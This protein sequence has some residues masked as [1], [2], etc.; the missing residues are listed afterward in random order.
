MMKRRDT[1]TSREP[2]RISREERAM[3]RAVR[4]D[5]KQGAHARQDIVQNT[6][7]GDAKNPEGFVKTWRTSSRAWRWRAV[8]CAFLSLL[9]LM[10]QPTGNALY[11]SWNAATGEAQGLGVAFATGEGE[12]AGDLV[13]AEISDLRT[14]G[15]SDLGG[16]SLQTASTREWPTAS[17]AKIK[18]YASSD[19][20]DALY[21]AGMRQLASGSLP[22]LYWNLHDTDNEYAHGDTWNELAEPSAANGQFGYVTWLRGDDWDQVDDWEPDAVPGVYAWSLGYLLFGWQVV[23]PGSIVE[24][25]SNGYISNDEGGSSSGV[26]FTGY[27]PENKKTILPQVT[28]SEQYDSRGVTTNHL[29]FS[30]SGMGADSSAVG[31]GTYY[32]VPAY[33]SWAK[34]TDYKVSMKVVKAGGGYNNITN[35]ST[36]MWKNGIAWDGGGFNDLLKNASGS[37][38][39]Y[40]LLKNATG[41]TW[42]AWP[43]NT[44]GSK[45][46]TSSVVDGIV[47]T[48][49]STLG[50]VVNPGG[51]STSP[52][53]DP[54]SKSSG[55]ISQGG[56]AGRILLTPTFAISYHPNNDTGSDTVE[57]HEVNIDGDVVVAE[58]T[59]S[60][61]ILRRAET[62]VGGTDDAFKGWSVGAADDT[63]EL[64]PSDCGKT[65]Q[66]LYDEGKLT[67]Y[68]TKT[69]YE[70]VDYYDLVAP[71]DLYAVWD[72]PAVT[73]T[74]NYVLNTDDGSIELSKTT[75]TLTGGLA[76]SLL[77]APTLQNATD[78]SAYSGAKYSGDFTWS[79][80]DTTDSGASFD[81]DTDTPTDSAHTYTVTLTPNLETYTVT[82][83]VDTDTGAFDNGVTQVVVNKVP[84]GTTYDQIKFDLINGAT[85][86]SDGKT[87]TVDY[88]SAKADTLSGVASAGAGIRGAYSD[89]RGN[90]NTWTGTWS[91]GGSGID[92]STVSV[93]GDTTLTYTYGEGYNKVTFA[94]GSATNATSTSDTTVTNAQATSDLE[95]S[96]SEA[97]VA[98]SDWTPNGIAAA[99]KP[100]AALKSSVSDY[101]LS[102]KYAVTSSTATLTWSAD[103][104]GTG[105]AHYDTATTFTYTA[106]PTLR[107]FTV[108]F[109]VRQSNGNTNANILVASGGADTVNYTTVPYGAYANDST[110]ITSA[111]VS[112]VYIGTSA[113]QTYSTENA[114][115]RRQTASSPN[116]T[117]ETIA[118]PSAVQVTKN[119]VIQ[120]LMGDAHTVT[121][122]VEGGTINGSGSTTNGT[123]ATFYVAGVPDGKAVDSI[124]YLTSSGAG[125]EASPY[126]YST[127]SGAVNVDGAKVVNTGRNT[128]GTWSSSLFADRAALS[129]AGVT[130]TA[131]AALSYEFGRDTVTV[132]YTIAD[133][134]QWTSG[135]SATIIGTVPYGKTIA[136]GIS[137]GTLSAI[138]DPTASGVV[139]VTK[140]AQYY[141]P[142]STGNAGTWSPEPTTNT[143]VE[144]AAKTGGS[145]VQTYAYTLKTRDNYSITYTIPEPYNTYVK[146]S[147]GELD[148]K[149]SYTYTNMTYGVAAGNGTGEQAAPPTAL[150][151]DTNSD[152]LAKIFTGGT[153][154]ITGWTA[155]DGTATY[156]QGITGDSTYYAQLNLIDYTVTYA[157]ENGSW[158]GSPA[159]SATYT[160]GQKPTGDIAALMSATGADSARTYNGTSVVTPSATYA[161]DGGDWEGVWTMTVDG[162]TT[163]LADGVS[164]SD[165]AITGNTIFTLT[166][167]RAVKVT[168]RN[169]STSIASGG[170]TDTT[171]WYFAGD[172]L[173]A[174]AFTTATA[175]TGYTKTSGNNRTSPYWTG[176]GE[177]PTTVPDSATAKTYTY[178]LRAVHTVTYKVENG[179]WLTWGSDTS[180][181]GTTT[182][183]SEEL[184][185]DV[186]SYTVP[187][188]ERTNNDY[189][190]TGSWDAEPSGTFTGSSNETH[191]YT[192]G[193][194]PTHAFTVNFYRQNTDLSTYETTPYSTYTVQVK[195]G[196]KQ[197]ITKAIAEQYAPDK[198]AGDPAGAFAL[199]TSDDG[200]AHEYT[201]GTSDITVAVYYNRNSFAYSYAY[202]YDSGTDDTKFR[203]P[204]VT[205]LPTGGTLPYGAELIIDTSVP[206]ASTPYY[207][208]GGWTTTAATISGGKLT[209]PASA[210]TLTGNWTRNS[211][212]LT[213]TNSDTGK[214]TISGT[215]SITAYQYGDSFTWP[216]VAVT[217]NTGVF[218]DKWEN[219]GTTGDTKKFAQTALPTTI[220]TDNMVFTT[221]SGLVATFS[222]TWNTGIKIQYVHDQTSV[223]GTLTNVG[224]FKEQGTGDNDYLSPDASGEVE[225][226]P[227]NTAENGDP[228]AAAY[229]EPGYEFLYW[230]WGEGANDH[231]T[232]SA[233][234]I[235]NPK[236]A[237]EKTD[238]AITFTAV[239]QGTPHN[240]TYDL[241][242]G[243]QTTDNPNKMTGGATAEYRTGAQVWLPSTSELTRAGCTLRGYSIKIG[244]ADAV[245]RAAT[246]SG[247]L[248]TI[249]AGTSDL[250]YRDII[251]IT[252]VYDTTVTF[253]IAGSEGVESA[254]TNAIDDANNSTTENL[255]ATVNLPTVTQSDTTMPTIANSTEFI[256]TGYHF[257][258]WTTSLP[259]AVLSIAQGDT[260]FTVPSETATDSSQGGAL[261]DFTGGITV[262]ANYAIDT[263]KTVWT[264]S[265]AELYNDASLDT[266]GYSLD[267]GKA[268]STISYGTDGD[269]VW[270][271]VAPTLT[272]N[273]ED[274]AKKY[275][276]TYQGIDWYL[277]V[278]GTP[279]EVKLQ[280]VDF[281]TPFYYNANGVCEQGDSGATPFTWTHDDTVTFV[282]VPIINQYTIKLAVEN[283]TM[284]DPTGDTLETGQTEVSYTVDYNTAY[285][286]FLE[287]DVATYA[288]T[289]DDAGGYAQ[290]TDPAIAWSTGSGTMTY[291]NIRE[292]LVTGDANVTTYTYTFPK[293]TY[294]VL[295]KIADAWTDNKAD[296][297]LSR[298]N[299]GTARPEI[300]AA[301]DSSAFPTL[302]AAS[303]WNASTLGEFTNKY[304]SALTWVL[305]NDTADP[306]TQITTGN[307]GDTM[308]DDA[309]TVTNT[310]LET[311]PATITFV[312]TPQTVKYVIKSNVSGGTFNN[313]TGVTDNVRTEDDDAVY[314]EMLSAYL[315]DV[316][317][318][319][320][321]FT[322]DDA[323][324]S[325]GHWETSTG[326][327]IDPATTPVTESETYVYVFDTKITV[328]MTVTNNTFATG[329]TAT[330][331]YYVAYNEKAPG[332]AVIANAV[333]SADDPTYVFAGSGTDYTEADAAAQLA[334][335]ANAASQVYLL[336]ALSDVQAT[337][338][339]YGY[340]WKTTG[341]WESSAASSTLTSLA[342]YPDGA[343]TGDPSS[344]SYP[345]VSAALTG[346][347]AYTYAME[348]KPVTIRFV[349]MGQNAED[350]NYTQIGTTSWAGSYSTSDTRFDS[351]V[352]YILDAPTAL[353]NYYGYVRTPVATTTGL[354]TETSGSY[355]VGTSAGDT[356]QPTNFSGTDTYYLWYDRMNVNYTY[357]YTNSAPTLKAGTELPAGTQTIR[358]GRAISNSTP[359]K[360]AA[361]I[362]ATYALALTVWNVSYNGF[363]TSSLTA[364]PGSTTYTFAPT[365]YADTSTATLDTL[366]ATLSGTWTTATYTVTYENA[367]GG[368]P[369]DDKAQFELGGTRAASGASVTTGAITWGETLG[370]NV[371]DV[372]VTEPDGEHWTKDKSDKYSLVGWKLYID[373]TQD[374]SVGTDG[375]IAPEDLASQVVKG[376]NYVYKPVFKLNQITITLSGGA[377]QSIPA[378]KEVTTW[379]VDYGTEIALP[380]TSVWASYT[381]TL[382]DGSVWVGSDAEIYPYADKSDAVRAKRVSDQK[383]VASNPAAWVTADGESWNTT[384]DGDGEYII[385]ATASKTYLYQWEDIL[386]EVYFMGITGETNDLKPLAGTHTARTLKWDSSV[387]SAALSTDASGSTAAQI[388]DAATG[389]TNRIL[390]PQWSGHTFLGWQNGSSEKRGKGTLAYPGT[391]I[392]VGAAYE[393]SYVTGNSYRIYLWPLWQGESL[394]VTFYK[395][396]GEDTETTKTQSME[397]D[398]ATNLLSTSDLGFSREGWNF[399][400]WTTE[401]DGA[402]INYVDGASYTVAEDSTA[403]QRSLY[404]K[405]SA[406]TY[407][408]RFAHFDGTPLTNAEVLGTTGAG[409]DGVYEQP[410][411]Y[412]TAANLATIDVDNVISA[413]SEHNAKGDKFAGWSYGSYTFTN[414]QEVSDLTAED[415]GVITLRPIATE[416]VKLTY[417]ANAGNETITGYPSDVTSFVSVTAKD[418]EGVS[419]NYA[420]FT[421][422]TA[423]ER[424]GYE[425]Q[426]WKITGAVDA[427]TDPVKAITT[428]PTSGDVYLS[429]EYGAYMAYAQWKA[430]EHTGYKIERW[431]QKEVGS[432]EYVLL[433]TD[434]THTAA[435]GDWVEIGSGALA[436]YS[437]SLD[438]Y[439]Y[440]PGLSTTGV[441]VT[442]GGTAAIVLKYN[443]D[444]LS[445]TYSFT[446]GVDGVEL[447]GAAAG[448]VPF[449]QSH[450]SLTGDSPMS[451]LLDPLTAAL[452]TGYEIVTGYGSAWRFAGP[453]GSLAQ[454]DGTAIVAQSDVAYDGTTAYTVAG[455][456]KLALPIVKK[457]FTVTFALG[458][459]AA[460]DTGA[461]ATGTGTITKTGV[462]YGSSVDP[463]DE[464]VKAVVTAVTN[465]DKE[466]GFGGWVYQNASDND[467]PK[468]GT[469]VDPAT[470]EIVGNTTFTAYYYESYTVTWSAGGHSA[471]GFSNTDENKRIRTQLPAAGYVWTAS[472][473]GATATNVGGLELAA[474]DMDAKGAPLAQDGYQFAGWKVSCSDDIYEVDSTTAKVNGT[475][476]ASLDELY[477]AVPPSSDYTIE[478]QWSKLTQTVIFD[479]NITG[480][481]SSSSA[482]TVSR[483]GL[484]G[485]TGTT[486]AAPDARAG[487]EFDCWQLS[488]DAT[489]QLGANK[490]FTFPMN[491]LDKA[492]TTYVAQWSEA[493]ININFAVSGGSGT[494]SQNR[495]TTQIKALDTSVEYTLKANP[496]P[497]Y[498]FVRWETSNTGTDISTWYNGSIT[499]KTHANY[500][501][502]TLKPVNGAYQAGTY[503]AVFEADPYEV[504]F[505][506]SATTGEGTVK[507]YY[508][509]D[510]KSFALV[511]YNQGVETV[512]DISSAT[513]ASQVQVSAEGSD[514]GY[515]FVGWSYQYWPETV[516]D[517]TGALVT[518][519]TPTSGTT[520]VPTDQLDTIPIV[521]KT[522][523][524]AVYEKNPS[525]ITYDK[526]ASAATGGISQ[527]TGLYTGDV[528][529]LPEA[530][531][532]ISWTGHTL[533]G[534]VTA[535]DEGNA[536]AVASMTEAEFDAYPYKAGA[537]GDEYAVKGGPETL[538]AMF[539]AVNA[540]L[541]YDNN[542]L[543]EVANLATHAT[544]N[545]TVKAGEDGTALSVDAVNWSEAYSNPPGYVSDDASETKVP[546][547]AREFVGWSFNANAALDG[548]SGRIFKAGDTIPASY[549]PTSATD[550][551]TI[552][553]IWKDKTFSVLL[554][555]N[556]GSLISGK[557]NPNPIATEVHY[558]D[559]VSVPTMMYERASHTFR[560]WI[561][562]DSSHTRVSDGGSYKFAGT[563]DVTLSAYWEKDADIVYKAQLTLKDENNNSL[564]EKKGPLTL[565]DTPLSDGSY[566]NLSVE[567]GS[568][569]DTSDYFTFLGWYM[570]TP[571]QANYKV[572]AGDGSV[573][574]N[575]MA[576]IDEIIKMFD[577]R[578]ASP[579]YW[580][581]TA[582]EYTEAYEAA[583]G[584]NYLQLTLYASKELK[585]YD[586]SFTENMPAVESGTGSAVTPIGDLNTFTANVS[587]ETATL[588]G[589]GYSLPGYRFLGWL[590]S[591]NSSTIDDASFASMSKPSDAVAKDHNLA[592][593][594]LS[595]SST[596]HAVTLYAAWGDTDNSVTFIEAADG[597]GVRAA[598]AGTEERQLAGDNVKQEDLTW[599]TQLAAVTNPSVHPE[600]EYADFTGWYTVNGKL[601][602]LETC[603]TVA[604]IVAIDSGLPMNDDGSYDIKLY[605]HYSFNSARVVYNGDGD[606]LVQ[607][608][609]PATKKVDIHDGAAPVATVEL[610]A[611]NQA[612]FKKAG[613]HMDGWEGKRNKGSYNN[614]ESGTNYYNQVWLDTGDRTVPFDENAA[615]TVVNVWPHY[616]E[617][618]YSVTYVYTLPDGYDSYVMTEAVPGK[619]SSN[620]N[621]TARTGLTWTGGSVFPR[622]LFKTAPV[623][624]GY[625][626]TGWTCTYDGTT[627]EVTS[628]WT[629][630]DMVNA[631]AAE[632]GV[633]VKDIEAAF[634]D[635]TFTLSAVWTPKTYAVAYDANGGL[636]ISTNAAPGTKTGV[637]WDA[638]VDGAGDGLLISASDMSKD[639]Y[640]AADPL[641]YVDSTLNTQ[642]GSTSN[643]TFAELVRAWHIA[644][645]HTAGSGATNK[646]P[647]GGTIKL[648]AKWVEDTVKISFTVS[649]AEN[650]WI[651]SVK[652]ADG[653]VLKSF[654]SL[655]S[656]QVDFVVGAKT[657]AVTYEGTRTTIDDLKVTVGSTTPG[658]SVTGWKSGTSTVAGA[659]DTY[660]VA[661][662]SDRYVNA[663]YE[664]QIE[665]D[666]NVEITVNFY[667]MDATGAYQANGSVTKHAG[668][669]L[670]ADNGTAKVGDVIPASRF[671]GVRTTVPE[672]LSLD[673]ST[674]ANYKVKA[675]G[676][677]VDLYY[678]RA[679]TDVTFSYEWP[680]GDAA[681]K[682]PAL[683]FDLQS[684]YYGSTQDVPDAPTAPAGYEFDGW[685]Q[686]RAGD[687]VATKLTPGAADGIA[688]DKL[689][690]V[691][692][693]G[694][695]TKKVYDVSFAG[696]YDEDGAMLSG[697]DVPTI[698]LSPEGF[699]KSVAYGATLGSDVCIVVTDTT[700]K[701]QPITLGTDSDTVNVA[702]KYDSSAYSITW[703]YSKDGT[704]WISTADPTKV[705]I[706]R[707]T[708]FR[709]IAS[710]AQVV[711]YMAGEHGTFATTTADGTRVESVAGPYSMASYLYDEASDDLKKVKAGPL[712]AATGLPTGEVGWRFAG[713]EWT[714]MLDAGYESKPEQTP[715]LAE[716]ASATDLMHAGVQDIDGL[717]YGITLTALWAPAESWLEV[718]LDDSTVPAGA[719]DAVPASFVDPSASPEGLHPTYDSSLGNALTLPG[720]DDVTR[721]GFTLTGWVATFHDD[722]TTAYYEA[723]AEFQMPASAKD[724]A[725]DPAVTLT[726]VWAEDY[727]T[728]NYY[729]VDNTKGTVDVA[730]ETVG[731]W[732]GKVRGSASATLAGSTATAQPNY[733]FTKWSKGS[734]D[735]A[736][737]TSGQ[738]VSGTKLKPARNTSTK[739]YEAADYYATFTGDSKRV[740]FIVDT[741][742]D[743]SG[744]AYTTM[745]SI[746][747]NGSAVSTAN[748]TELAVPYGD[749]PTM[750]G[751][752]GQKTVAAK[753]N[754]PTYD[755]ADGRYWDYYVNTS[756][757]SL[758]PTWVRKGSTDDPTKVA[759]TAE[760]QFRVRFQAYGGSFDVK[761]DAT[762]SSDTFDT[763]KK[764]W[765]D[766]NV[767]AGKTPTRTGYEFTGWF[768]TPYGQVYASA[769]EAA[770]GMLPAASYTYGQL[771]GGESHAA[772]AEENGITL[773][774]GWRE[775]TGYTVTLSANGGEMPDPN[776]ASVM[777]KTAEV[778]SLSW[779]TPVL[780][781]VNNTVAPSTLTR[782]GYRFTGWSTSPEGELV[783]SSEKYGDLAGT[784]DTRP[785]GVTLYAQWEEI[786]Y[787][788]R[789]MNWPRSADDEIEPGSVSVDRTLKYND[790]VAM[791]EPWNSKDG[792][793]V[794]DCWKVITGT[795]DEP[796]VSLTGQRASWTIKDFESNGV[797]TDSDGAY[798]VYGT[799]TDYITYTTTYVLYD[800][801]YDN[802]ARTA[803]LG[804]PPASG[805][806]D[807]KYK[808]YLVIEEK[809]LPNETVTPNIDK[810]PPGFDLNR[811]MT[812]KYNNNNNASVPGFTP[813]A[814]FDAISAVL[815]SS[816]AGPN[817][818]VVVV[819]KQGYSLAFNMNDTSATNID[820]PSGKTMRA[821]TGDDV[822]DDYEYPAQIVKD[823]FKIHNVP[824]SVY[825][826]D[827]T[828]S[829]EALKDPTR[830]GFSFA[831]WYNL[832]VKDNE[833]VDPNID[834][835]AD[836]EVHYGELAFD[837]N[838]EWY[839]PMD[840]DRG[841]L[842][843]YAR[844]IELTRTV[845]Y[846]VAEDMKDLVKIRLQSEA[847]SAYST[848]E[849]TEVIGAATGDVFIDGVR[850]ADVAQ[851]A[852]AQANRG[853]SVVWRIVPADTAALSKTY[854]MPLGATSD[855]TLATA[856]VAVAELSTQAAAVVET[857]VGGAASGTRGVASGT[858]GTPTT[859]EAESDAD[860]ELLALIL[861]TQGE[862]GGTD[863]A[864]SSE[865]KV[866]QASD[867]ITPAVE[868]GSDGSG[869]FVGAAM[870][871]SDTTAM[872]V[873]YVATATQNAS[874]NI[875]FNPGDADAYS[876][877]SRLSQPVGTYVGE[878]AV[879][880]VWGVADSGSLPD[881]NTIRRVGYVFDGWTSSTALT[882]V[883]ENG[884]IVGIPAGAV[885]VP[886][887]WMANHLL[888]P[889]EGMTLTASWTEGTTVWTVVV[890]ESTNPNTGEVVPATTIE[891]SEGETLTNDQIAEILNRGGA[892]PD[893][894]D[895]SYYDVDGTSHSAKMTTDELIAFLQGNPVVSDMTIAPAAGAKW[896]TEKPD[897]PDNTTNPK[898]PRVRPAKSNAAKTGDS[899]VT[900]VPTI[901]GIALAATAVLFLLLS[902][903]RRRE[904]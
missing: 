527:V 278:G 43:V 739:R 161:K 592:T 299:D 205:T 32:Y 42:S 622:D 448:S 135:S 414:G 830:T 12:E 605:A 762:P 98:Y 642:A 519:T 745:G 556:G 821:V 57:P 541:V 525:T 413:T 167:K 703:A 863:T 105:T 486:P 378:I 640:T 435:T 96:A 214:G 362:D 567:G 380:E 481:A 111:I 516:D 321:G 667:D 288:L 895:V 139:T 793:R 691:S 66:A 419:R 106:Q 336:T 18:Y 587:G 677:V 101:G 746:T 696:V 668:D 38:K 345:N 459:N 716:D 326:S 787:T 602:N 351:L 415:G 270:K 688:V 52:D 614:T 104:A 693:V 427:T 293:K 341:G 207:T 760:T 456:A 353:N 155:A 215:T 451:T 538:Y 120:M 434:S 851:G 687:T 782:A 349:L 50:T 619:D 789:Y 879:D 48:D 58:I 146:F 189:Y 772:E 310:T 315:P 569:V 433:G 591:A 395:N 158:T 287:A 389:A 873:L 74:V 85:S 417:D 358:Y 465:P 777:V 625:D 416:R 280:D 775:L 660:G 466:F 755:F 478:A 717:N 681:A 255:G 247:E 546:G 117:W 828:L 621:V 559:T 2:R 610:A 832:P 620:A 14:A 845:H 884:N 224:T 740:T 515:T 483:Q 674:L 651:S 149:T 657:G 511:E 711:S 196:F 634:A 893:T 408:V 125:T 599:R 834:I 309:A 615:G 75:D 252:A 143:V 28:S 368:D 850:E 701:L 269:D 489:V 356:F 300:G 15:T 564:V 733:T 598:D 73:H 831:G 327:V 533:L 162:E 420:K 78:H 715:E 609:L 126:I 676:N 545:V 418:A 175:N 616:A 462:T 391:D 457:T 173:T 723:G 5:A 397:I 400:G 781:R 262:T 868:G 485:D 521:G 869:L 23:K 40:S 861:T 191:T 292:L 404:A 450:I 669:F 708:V 757:S 498:R 332:D 542:G 199:A 229:H 479:P 683:P 518:A 588:A 324:M 477:K 522:V 265:D 118:G 724:T 444:A 752:T 754:Y 179:K 164:P 510:G 710:K 151:S 446:E 436:G 282:A 286:S 291:L 502:L 590:T 725:D 342:Q 890:P 505:Q 776:D 490:A 492:V 572:V 447:S 889:E 410:F 706:E 100:T 39:K 819:A 41:V 21:W 145:W 159:T 116:E 887:T 673:T 369:N 594:L 220:N 67:S 250:N 322:H 166:L 81:A 153:P 241:N 698:E 774:A 843:L 144:P 891:V 3:L 497:G 870:D 894:W 738:G 742:T 866:Y 818:D 381:S 632:K 823:F 663:T 704:T 68:I 346:D 441:W 63:A 114:T 216:T 648:Y 154:A 60:D 185:K 445:V 865:G 606:A 902:L 631:L 784:N 379:T 385:S 822:E 562:N 506:N 463:A 217:P 226:T 827:N 56:A 855:G 685:Y 496:A 493:V 568:L 142:T 799:W 747:V 209:M 297:E 82:A 360:V 443:I 517:A 788:V 500:G 425:F 236:G 382:S 198:K 187:T 129:G 649:D 659:V 826:V 581:A 130:I 886:G 596:A 110:A 730:T 735:A 778:E 627:V 635:T 684:V 122:S 565:L 147:G 695:F 193:A 259:A 608:T 766:S 644:N 371:P 771:A 263:Y 123:T 576:T 763:I 464:S 366:T 34:R 694:M 665:G 585:K 350:D 33:A 186:D 80:V 883:D 548:S 176:D 348:A 888:V 334:Y 264:Y 177:P 383:L 840:H 184:F 422:P 16:V 246:A 150:S 810:I 329:D 484:S 20:A 809:G 458:D 743:S 507:A 399:L 367:G 655:E 386:Y 552:Y 712:D 298:T 805:F 17:T 203:T 639:G 764:K 99:A 495:A 597:D 801:E 846:I 393:E 132:N 852:I 617:N 172:T 72:T 900:M 582:Q 124:T 574:Q 304:E 544:K 354:G 212:T 573:A 289:A 471:S 629:V 833:D 550:T 374:T 600:N 513:K 210:V 744:V 652:K 604:D 857:E 88:D 643:P 662:A 318:A 319:T 266:T 472:D 272:G 557:S 328:T 181:A 238:T 406:N 302:Q 26:A 170:Y 35:T 802:P 405:W 535:D 307:Y 438:G 467:D 347:V 722:G 171:A 814:N 260:S 532:G 549:M 109:G 808:K 276:S 624:E 898:D 409:A 647:D 753:P 426:G 679:T 53:V 903:R 460:W 720:A 51:A 249:P 442:G 878:T 566:E 499:D 501:L 314:G 503:T 758:S 697:D 872:G 152:T 384:A 233:A 670:N 768:V 54:F 160:Y 848:E 690:G 526:N 798:L 306:Q 65:L 44:S 531:D 476:Y 94:L 470:T 797:Q 877:P 115:W 675:S 856:S 194:I 107:E 584:T 197:A 223:G 340:Q 136:D 637:K 558:G 317:D 858:R 795:D 335:R 589:R 780:S 235:V 365:E 736:A 134:G 87:L 859:S 876:G 61:K 174:P 487:Y 305:Q 816:Q 273:N 84:Y 473:A 452:P 537:V 864:T 230:K 112:G 727:V 813:Y 474:A 231:A 148:T 387:F 790:V 325:T 69:T 27:Y 885:I 37:G 682:P 440:M 504:S 373:G 749:A 488:T 530:G 227:Y 700:G 480:G 800:A 339:N 424:S 377:Y 645:N 785:G 76:I 429:S 45:V 837:E 375:V 713:W 523:F 239:Y 394:D 575:R 658:Y 402:T 437:T 844:W 871:A 320:K 593:P 719:T 211:V 254:I 792:D 180:V 285:S 734:A 79:I 534:W 121:V 242:G 131:N 140:A 343:T 896:T 313:G 653:T 750:D 849:R 543:P 163:T 55:Y 361:P 330:K 672:G 702:V 636:L 554:D 213:L 759:I 773:L 290:L 357:S 469:V 71:V 618:A 431:V 257:V 638:K 603:K 482:E 248:Y 731:T 222:A 294:Q 6:A 664:A 190:E 536:P 97:Y 829:G 432:T 820:F 208:F 882:Y 654:A 244:G 337:S 316:T 333:T 13:P 841:V 836:D 705:K 157:I 70:R 803:A 838:G 650:G 77:A 661:A 563:S 284:T 796:G 633:D 219:A 449:A 277:V 512:A 311:Y 9:L 751:S 707:D 392:T 461:G 364:T 428:N 137:A 188:S 390:N 607:P 7:F 355:A 156:G 817:F 401:R 686:L 11:R 718:D 454:A 93:N 577:G 258:N 8:L 714:Y 296:I 36:A 761:F 421:L 30:A 102:D 103:P 612:E 528:I 268:Y 10:M 815:S 279:T 748:E 323:H 141:D 539:E 767:G 804:D 671:E 46:G 613:Y 853:Y 842:T 274:F 520:T 407:K 769:T 860:A 623:L 455:N 555:A 839:D 370:A 514:P 628:G 786:E 25:V 825:D 237:N 86:S 182:D 692:V 271:T 64:E 218:F 411:T 641:W 783:T 794:W 881:R 62:S 234:D 646:F 19:E 770:P 168:I 508:N 90:T 128:S 666:P 204:A 92:L 901:A 601:V 261:V 24:T 22:D 726:A 583:T 281:G 359:A 221:S 253:A 586:V 344:V 680:D 363:V 570:Y 854:E 331:T 862:V 729:S 779:T 547:D 202:T 475:T 91:E 835:K 595:A 133:G 875:T 791:A 806:D 611:V 108:T 113:N 183:L 892:Y 412:G 689:D 83:D 509:N 49:A 396:A 741:G 765:S 491:P 295:Y 626:L 59:T 656:S 127:D 283:G 338:P 398:V 551:K 867:A 169:D 579:Q 240:V 807:E 824:W 560:Y 553:A 540:T 732:T 874:K 256:K 561:A 31:D 225:I 468:N 301:Y 228:N 352:E 494:V 678:K 403:A 89:A 195:E 372:Y 243:T 4:H 529:K 376:P 388:I 251:T 201:M 275:N 728:I 439:V 308:R 699:S 232:N 453:A 721:A 312:G 267:S 737:M 200:L 571:F 811:T 245:E 29:A 95:L 206:N 119:E 899:L 178:A 423:P 630:E 904:E 524:T 1:G 880:G 47:L 430:D 138:P 192:Y 756:D 580:D 165:V 897:I 847:E 303:T 812:V 578:V 709:A